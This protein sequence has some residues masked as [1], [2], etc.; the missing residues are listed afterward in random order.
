M[1]GLLEVGFVNLFDK[2]KKRNGIFFPT[3]VVKNN[4][5][6]IIEKMLED[7]FIILDNNFLFVLLK[8]W[9][10][11]GSIISIS[12]T[13][14]DQVASFFRFF[15]WKTSYEDIFFKCN[16]RLFCN[17]QRFWCIMVI[18]ITN[19]EHLS[20]HHIGWYFR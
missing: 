7:Q 12:Y 13:E 3:S 8:T 17:S 4:F 15:W 6:L 10:Y 18:N 2:H 5:G 9:L 14:R 1:L 11:E 16:S 20:D 19:I